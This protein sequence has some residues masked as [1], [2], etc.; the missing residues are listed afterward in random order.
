M[1]AVTAGVLAAL[2]VVV[3]SHCL[4]AEVSVLSFLRCEA[5]CPAD[6]APASHCDDA[7][8]LTLEAGHFVLA[9][10]AKAPMAVLG[11]IVLDVSLFSEGLQASGPRG[12]IVTRVP[13]DLPKIWQFAFRAALPPRAPASVA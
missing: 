5:P 3:G 11:M 9:G 7:A 10:Q 12:G 6:S 1:R 13:P 8:C 4:L 2:W